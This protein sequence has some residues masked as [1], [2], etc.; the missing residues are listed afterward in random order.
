M[1]AKQRDIVFFMLDQLS[2]KWLETAVDGVCDLPNIAWMLRNGTHFRNA[3]TSNPVCMPARATLAT[4]LTSRQHGC[5]QNGYSLDPQLPTFMKALQQGGYAT[6]ALGKVHLRPHFDGF[7]PDYRV[8]GYDEIHITEDGRGGEWLDWVRN[9]H[10]AHFDAALATIWANHI[11]ELF[12]YGIENENLSERIAEIRKRF[13]WRQDGF[14]HNDAGRYTLPFPQEVS[15]TEWITRHAERFIASIPTGQAL[16]AHISYVQPHSPFCPPAPYMGRVDTDRL[17][18]PSPVEWADNPPAAFR[19]LRTA[20]TEI[21]DDWRITRQYYFA[22]MV[23]LDEQLGRV[24]TTLRMAGRMENTALVL[25]ADHGEML[26]DHGFRGKGEFHYDACC[27]VPLIMAGPGISTGQTRQEFVQLEDICPTV[28]DL[29]E[30]PLFQPPTMGPYLR[31]K[32]T[33]TL[34]GRSLLPLCRGEIVP[35]WRD[36]AYIESF[37]NIDSNSPR[38]WART[39]HTDRYRYTYYPCGGGEQLFDLENDPAEQI[40]LAEEPNHASIRNELRDRL[41]E[42]VIL[43]DYPH[44]TRNLFAHGVH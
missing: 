27:R 31:D 38:H 25:L 15:Q 10:S 22:D 33:T 35:D 30:Q 20:Q 17:P 29:A 43:Q 3:Y 34:S 18:Q 44:P 8:Y 14:P 26:L 7:Y 40:N 24:L 11:P 12:D 42:K 36:T 41:L 39:L 1:N 2:A 19:S 23:H 21:A 28:L 4:G 13:D 6:A 37:N 5:L 9:G 32:P 16:H